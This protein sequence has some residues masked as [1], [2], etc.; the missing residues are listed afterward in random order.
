MSADEI[1][2]KKQDEIIAE[3]QAELL[4]IKKDTIETSEKRRGW[5]RAG[6]VFWFVLLISYVVV[7]YTGTADGE[8]KPEGVDLTHFLKHPIVMFG[9]DYKRLP[10]GRAAWVKIDNTGHGLIAKTIYANP[11]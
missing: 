1:I 4:A 9:H 11:P 3:L 2:D 10:I 5:V 6:I 7:R 8:I